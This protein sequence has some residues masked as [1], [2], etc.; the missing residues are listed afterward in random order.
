MIIQ[1]LDLKEKLETTNLK[2]EEVKLMPLDVKNMYLLVWLRVIWKVL[3][4]YVRNLLEED[5]K[6]IN[7]CLE[8]IKFGVCSTLIQYH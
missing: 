2:R 7:A 8:M 5:K 6:T 3:K 4:Y 1:A